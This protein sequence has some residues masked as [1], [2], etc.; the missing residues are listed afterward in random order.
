M[1]SETV[2]SSILE[3]TSDILATISCREGKPKPYSS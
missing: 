2:G 1:Q 3:G